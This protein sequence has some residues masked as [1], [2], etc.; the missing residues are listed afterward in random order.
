[1]VSVKYLKPVNSCNFIDNSNNIICC[2]DP[3]DVCI[4]VYNREYVLSEWD[5]KNESVPGAGEV[6]FRVNQDKGYYLLKISDFEGH[7]DTYPFGQGK[8]E[9]I[10]EY[11]LRV[12]HT[13]N[14]VNICHFDLNAHKV[15][16][17]FPIDS[18][19]KSS[20]VKEIIHSIRERIL[21]KAIR[22]LPR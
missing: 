10:R 5:G 11:R 22:E 21:E 19:K 4:E 15:H 12:S 8:A 13:P 16:E 7:I 6:G 18:K 2:T 17:Q 20:W 1:M 14:M 3:E 9:E